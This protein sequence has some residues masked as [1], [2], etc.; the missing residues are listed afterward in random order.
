MFYHHSTVTVLL[1]K[2]DGIAVKLHNQYI[3]Q[4]CIMHIL[5]KPLSDC[6]NSVL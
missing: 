6:Y 4:Q 1:K 5:R 2:V 3:A